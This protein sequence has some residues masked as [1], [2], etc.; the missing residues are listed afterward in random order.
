M[1]GRL[2]AAGGI[3]FQKRYLLYQGT[4]AAYG[5][6]HVG[7]TREALVPVLLGGCCSVVLD[8]QLVC[9]VVT[10]AHASARA[11]CVDQSSMLV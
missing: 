6:S 2:P 11:G 8:D 10:T 3:P 9:G 4:T 5:G 1:G 7:G